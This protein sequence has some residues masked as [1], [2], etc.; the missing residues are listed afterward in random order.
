MNRR[1]SHVLVCLRYGIGDLVMELPVIDALRRAMP[2]ATFTGLGAQPAIEILEG[3]GRF[4]EVVPIQRWGIRHLGD[5][6]DEETLRDFAGWLTSSRFD[7]ILD[8]SHAANALKRVIDHRDAET[9]DSYPPY[10][11]EGLTLGMDGLSAV[12]YAAGLGWGLSVPASSYPAVLLREEEIDWAQRFLEER[13]MTGCVGM[14]PGASGNLKRW[15]VSHFARFCRHVVVE[16]GAPVLVF[17][18]PTEMDLLRVLAAQTR[19]C[20][21]IATAECLHLRQVAALLSQS[22]LYVGND[23]G[24]MHLAAASGTPVVALFGPTVPHIYLPTWVPARAVVSPVV[25]PHQPRQAFGH[26]RCALEGACFLGPPCIE[27]IDPAAV[28]AAVKQIHENIGSRG[29]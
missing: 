24:L 15:P 2:Q 17:G 22:R 20:R 26:P 16:L 25:C 23:S 5:S 27:A 4:D 13:G 9:R 19:G 21:H 8:S 12:K 7:L 1:A 6:A 29:E 18:G 10:L 3:D 11:N 14:S 28:C